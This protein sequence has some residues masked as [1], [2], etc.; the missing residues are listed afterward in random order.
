MQPALKKKVLRIL[1]ANFN[2]A[3]EGIRVCEEVAR[4]VLEDPVLTRRAQKLRYELTRISSAFAAR[5]LLDSRNVKEDAGRP[6][7]RGSATTHR[8]CKEI[9]LANIRRAQEALRVLEEFSR[10]ESPGL[11]RRFSSVRF[12][13]YALEQDFFSKL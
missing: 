10:L 6:A 7:L 5:S 13:A 9:V 8:G 11:S 1:D 3:R 2:R 12:R 4:L